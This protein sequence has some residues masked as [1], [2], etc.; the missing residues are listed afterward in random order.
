MLAVVELGGRTTGFASLEFSGLPPGLYPAL[1]GLVQSPTLEV[2]AGGNIA[3]N[4][5]FTELARQ[6]LGRVELYILPL[7]AVLLLLVF[8]SVVAVLLPL[9]VGGLAMAGAIAGMLLLARLVSV[10][11]YAPNIVSMIGL[12]VAIDYSLFVVSRFR[13]E[14]RDHPGPEAL[15]RTL[16]TAGRSILFSGLTVAI[17]L[18]GM[19]FLGLGNLASM[20]WAGTIVVGLAVL[21][22]LTT[23]PA[24]LAVLGPRVNAG[25]VPLLHREPS[26]AGRGVWQRLARV[27][28]AHPWRVLVPVVALLLLLGLPFLHLRVGS[29]DATALPPEAEARR[30]DELL[31]REFPGGGVNRII[32]LLD[33]GRGSALTPA[34]VAQAFALSRWIGTMPH[35]SR[36]DSFVDLDP[37][38]DPPAYQ[39]M[40]TLPREHVALL[41]VNTALRPA[42]D[43][44]RALV[45]E[46]PSHSVPLAAPG[47]LRQALL[48]GRAAL[49]RAL[50]AI[51]QPHRGHRA[52]DDRRVAG[53]HHR[54]PRRPTGR[55]QDPDVRPGT[56][57]PRPLRAIVDGRYRPAHFFL[58]RTSSRGADQ[59]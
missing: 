21:Y 3:L 32:V 2:L 51:R 23:L 12:G 35:V 53:A 14:I 4:H 15:S 24:L 31:R 39:A 40:A 36:V 18:L 26:A 9:A 22:G 25:R 48:T 28:M 1:R 6:D 57:E 10:S 59:G 19:V 7:V 44:A 46:M 45:R 47:T 43:E 8:G 30:A 52:R 54:R 37:S 56:A 55:R 29:G 33:A 13:E 5:D 17:G 50:G 38:L 58:S 49:P 16:A 34:R 42:S 20:G 27:V 41:V 11:I